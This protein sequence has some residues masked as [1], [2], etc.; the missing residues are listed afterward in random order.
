MLALRKSAPAFVVFV[1][2]VAAAIGFGVHQALGLAVDS[3][4]QRDGEV[5]MRQWAGYINNRLPDLEEIVATGRPTPEQLGKLEVMREV[6]NVFQFRLFAPDGT[7]ILISDEVSTRASE[8][9]VGEFDPLARTA[10]QTG[11]SHIAVR[12]G[13]DEAGKP[14]VYVQSYVRAHGAGGRPIGIFEIFVDQTKMASFLQAIFGW[15]AAGLALLGSLAY[16]IPSFAFLQ[17]NADANRAENKV[18]YLTEFDPLTSLMSRY[19]FTERL[20]RALARPYAYLSPDAI[21]FIDIDNFKA[22]NDEYGH[23]GGDQFIVHVANAIKSQVREIGYAARFGGDEF[24]ISMPGITESGLRKVCDKILSAARKP[25]QCGNQ[26]IKGE[27]SIG[28]HMSHQK[29]SSGDLLRAADIALYN[30]K[31]SG[32][33]R[34]VLFNENM[35]HQLKSRRDLE[36]RLQAAHDQQE[37]ELNY[38]PI[39]DS[40]TSKIAGFEALLRLP[41]GN[42]GYIPPDQFIPVAESIGLIAPI[43][44]WAMHEALTTAKTWPGKLFISVNL[45]PRQFE[46][47]NLVSTIKSAVQQTGFPSDRLELEVTESLFLGNTEAVDLQIKELKDLGASIALDDFGTGY[48]SIGYLIRYGFNKLKVDRS[49][50]LAHDKDPEKLHGVLETIVSLGHGL[51]MCVTAEGIETS[52]QAKMLGE[53]KCDQFQGFHFGKPMDRDNVAITLLR[54]TV[55]TMAEVKQLSPGLAATKSRRAAT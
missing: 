42:G 20:D 52:D 2:I 16:L 50:L 25:A 40:G 43:S 35:A 36:R 18:S 44:K 30:A 4:V 34:V 29:S 26:V 11:R 13:K 1:L 17:R 21:V 46:D 7:P 41:D 5:R 33:N 9:S 10:F 8:D 6:G 47:G 49:F 53:L 45:S 39:I 48:S 37:F 31:N 15:V 38:Q 3:A 54:S 19:S 14:D 22:I 28:A 51:G 12:S 55:D 32:K 24:I 23:E 27:I